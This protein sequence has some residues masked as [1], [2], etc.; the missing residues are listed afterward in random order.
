MVLLVSPNSIFKTT[1]S[2]QAQNHLT[3][4]RIPRMVD[5]PPK[6]SG[7]ANASQQLSS[8]MVPMMTD[9]VECRR[10]FG[11]VPHGDAETLKRGDTASD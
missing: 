7:F 3:E 9:F 4:I 6:I 1:E 5:L 2:E 8:S 10:F 11:E